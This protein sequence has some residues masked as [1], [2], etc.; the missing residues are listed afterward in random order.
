MKSN[1]RIAIDR[2][3]NVLKGQAMYIK[4]NNRLSIQDKKEQLDVVFKMAEYLKEYSQEVQE[5]EDTEIDLT[6]E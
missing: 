4:D 2:L 5:L 6:H 1:R 3:Q